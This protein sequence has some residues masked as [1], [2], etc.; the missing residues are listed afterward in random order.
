[1][2]LFSIGGTLWRHK[3]VSIPLVLL[4]L[5]GMLCI[6]VMSPPTYQA[7][8]DVLLTNPPAAPTAIEI[9]QN[10][11]LAKTYNPLAN[12][13]DLTYVA[14]MLIDV[15]TDP[16]VKHA[17]AQAGASGYQVV[18]DN[19]SQTNIPPAI[20][21]TGTGPNA[22]AAMQS[23]QLVATTI[24]SDLYQL[25]ANQ[26]VQ[27]KYMITAVEYVEP[28]S[29]TKASSGKLQTAIGVAAVGLIVLLVAI[30]IAQGREEQKNR[31]PR[32]ERPSA[33]HEDGHREAANSEAELPG[34][35]S[36]LPY[37]E[38]RPA[39]RMG[40]SYPAG[41]RPQAGNAAERQRFGGQSD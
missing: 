5:L 41:V 4:T 36:P 17:L 12:L 24:S 27:S 9:A 33:Y 34:G 38:P 35:E 7:K 18:L 23:A 25:Q 14:E 6:I 26:H 30:S 8:A 2:D 39:M 22:Q 11:D 28:N 40:E 16:A 10:P 37:A 32:Q 31:R 13:G 3:R 20:D 15:V 29:A 19:A 21:V 1:M